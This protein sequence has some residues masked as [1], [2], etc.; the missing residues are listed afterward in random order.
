[1]SHSPKAPRGHGSESS[2]PLRSANHSLNKYCEERLG[3]PEDGAFKRARVAKLALQFPRAVDELRS[4]EIHLTGLLQLAPHLTGDNADALFTEAR[5][6]PRREI[7]LILAR[8]FPRPDVPPRIQTL[9]ASP[10]GNGAGAH[11]GIPSGPST[12]N[13]RSG[14]EP[15]RLE[16][17]SAERYR[18][19]FSASAEFR[20]KLE[21]ARE[22]LS[23][24]VPSGDIAVVLAR[25]R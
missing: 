17:L 6:K 13:F 3:Y 23:H 15:F 20:G 9:G 25:A 19:E 5:G 2:T 8:R 21:Q 1:M 10:S 24:S 14:A 16:P 22:L 7:A 18:I 11:P 12:P 4:G